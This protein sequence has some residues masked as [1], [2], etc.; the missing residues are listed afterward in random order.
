VN[1]ICADAVAAPDCI[2]A[3]PYAIVF[4]RN[5]LIYLNEEA[6][7]RL[8]D[9]L[10]HWLASDGLLFVG[11]T[12]QLNSLHPRFQLVPH[13]GAF[14]LRR[15]D[16]TSAEAPGQPVTRVPP[17]RS[18]LGSD[19]SQR[20]IGAAPLGPP[21]DERIARTYGTLGSGPGQ[22]ADGT[23]EDRDA[24]QTPTGFSLLERARTAADQGHLDAALTDT[25]A[26]LQSSPPS[27]ELY[28]LLGSLQLSLGRLPA[29]RDAL[30]RAV[31]LDPDR[32]ESLLQLAIVYQCLG[33]D[34][35]AARYRQRAARAHQRKAGGSE[36]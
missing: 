35:Q 28:Q 5:L 30:R 12:E 9:N 24:G 25:Q 4:C 15:L 27:A 33:A 34:S 6:R 17:L 13:P 32:E 19:R 16:A 3:G 36:Q 20:R 1:F 29:A 22:I 26:A 14:A 18:P 10:A 8:V 7:N 11:H 31:Y 2:P 23:G 21:K